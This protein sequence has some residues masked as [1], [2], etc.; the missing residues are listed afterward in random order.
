MEPTKSMI[1]AGARALSD[2]T[3][4]GKWETFDED[5]KNEY[6]KAAEAC[7]RA[8]IK[9]AEVVAENNTTSIMTVFHGSGAWNL[10]GAKL[11]PDDAIVIIRAEVE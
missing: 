10:T 4:R 9:G 2:H 7:L 8:A 1:E 5:W 11:Y 3:C 6:R